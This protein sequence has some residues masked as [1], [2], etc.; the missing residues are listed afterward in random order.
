VHAAV[1]L[2]HVGVLKSLGWKL[3]RWLDVVVMEKPLGAGDSN[4]PQ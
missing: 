4:P 2:S 1:V 3:E